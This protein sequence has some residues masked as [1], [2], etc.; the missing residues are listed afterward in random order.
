MRRAAPRTSGKSRFTPA[1]PV[2]YC[3]APSPSNRSCIPPSPF[4]LQ[5]HSTTTGIA[6]HTGQKRYLY[7]SLLLFYL[8]GDF[9]VPATFGPARKTQTAGPRTD[10]PTH[11]LVKSRVTWFRRLRLDLPDASLFF[12]STGPSLLDLLRAN[13]A[14]SRRRSLWGCCRGCMIGS[15]ACSGMSIFSFAGRRQPAVV[16]VRKAATA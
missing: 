13:I 5:D 14:R 11:S 6:N 7:I 8:R 2:L 3:G 12:H 16:D 9:R 15:S 10:P 4:P 1:G